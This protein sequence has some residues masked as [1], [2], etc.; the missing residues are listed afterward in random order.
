VGTRLSLVA[1]GVLLLLAVTYVVTFY[2]VTAPTRDPELD[3]SGWFCDL[4]DALV[5]G[6][7]QCNFLGPSPDWR[8]YSEEYKHQRIR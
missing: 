5:P 4:G 2:V 1:L 6:C 8:W 3:H 7:A